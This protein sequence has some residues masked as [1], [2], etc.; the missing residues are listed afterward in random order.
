MSSESNEVKLSRKERQAALR[1]ARDDV[2]KVKKGGKAGKAGKVDE[3]AT[4]VS[5]TPAATETPTSPSPA[6]VAAPVARRDFI[7][8][9]DEP[10]MESPESV[11]YCGV[12]GGPPE[13]CQYDPDTW[14]SCFKWLQEHAPAHVEGVDAADILEKPAK[15]TKAVDRNVVITKQK[16]QKGKMVTCVEGLELYDV[17]LSEACKAFKKKFACSATT[18]PAKD[19][20]PQFVEIQ[21]DVM[22]EVGEVIMDM[23]DLMDDDLVWK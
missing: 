16:R 5:S 2:K 17:L 11:L 13:I 14:P 18:K 19:G 20:K 12:C 22:E 1:K 15:K 23:Y 7:P 9:A 21:G 3:P 6:P 4:E 8:I 10:A